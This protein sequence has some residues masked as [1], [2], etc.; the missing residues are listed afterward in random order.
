MLRAGRNEPDPLLTAQVLF[1]IHT[2]AFNQPHLNASVSTP[3][4]CLHAF[5]EFSEFTEFGEF[6]ELN[7]DP[8]EH[9]V[10]DELLLGTHS[11]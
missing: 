7:P 8:Q 5:S 3:R 9:A 11:L 1:Y 4:P 2:A 10:F 6:S